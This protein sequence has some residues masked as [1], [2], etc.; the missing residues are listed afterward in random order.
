M[1]PATLN[2]R[3]EMVYGS[4]ISICSVTIWEMAKLLKKTAKVSIRKKIAKDK[5]TVKRA[6]LGLARDKVKLLSNSVASSV[7]KPFGSKAL[8][9]LGPG[10]LG[11]VAWDATNPFHLPLP[12][13]TGPYQVVRLTRTWT[14]SSGEQT[15]ILG[16]FVSD[17]ITG[18]R[19][20][21][22]ENAICLFN[23]LPL[24]NAMNATSGVASRCLDVSSLGDGT[25]LVPSAFTVTLMNGNA[26]QTTS[27]VIYM[28]RMNSCPTLANVSR[29]WQSFT[30]T[31]IANHSPRLLS[32]A[33]LAMGAVKCSA[34]PANMSALGNFSSFTSSTDSTF[35]WN[36]TT[37]GDL[38]NGGFAP[39]VIVKPAGLTLTVMVTVELRIRF[40]PDH[41]ASSTHV[42]HKA[43]PDTV[44]N[45]A[46]A[47][48]VSAGHG[49]YDIAEAGVDVL[50]AVGHL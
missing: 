45:D 44:W 6:K 3:D 48:A 26:L 43:V 39:I 30:D 18:G 14:T 46:I 29:T 41:I 10:R 4:N 17:A 25:T 13:T 2:I 42:H 8:P 12:V 1:S 21:G 7:S 50:D 31:F 27:G 32:A 19:A 23:A 24:S 5:S 36:G 15:L 16:P 35:T 9:K 38:E 11:R 22:W 49:V 37:S 20:E 33:K 34:I 47:A 28:G 40:D